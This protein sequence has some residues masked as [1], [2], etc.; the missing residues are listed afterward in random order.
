MGLIGANKAMFNKRPEGW[1]IGQ[2]MYNFLVWLAE[3]GLESLFVA[4]N[5][6]TETDVEFADPF[7]IDDAILK[8]YYKEFLKQYEE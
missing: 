6:H 5:K 4:V 2:T 7:F 1:R 3:Q 8:K